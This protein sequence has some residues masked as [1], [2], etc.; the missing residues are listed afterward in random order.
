MMKPLFFCYLLFCP[1]LLE[2]QH[3]IRHPETDVSDQWQD[4]F[5]SQKTWELYGNA[6]INKRKIVFEKWE[7][8]H[9]EWTIE[10]ERLQINSTI[11]PKIYDWGISIHEDNLIVISHPDANL[12]QEIPGLNEQVNFYQITYADQEWMIL[13]P[14]EF[15]PCYDIEARQFLTEADCAAH[16]KAYQK[17]RIPFKD[18]L[19]SLFYRQ[20][21]PPHAIVL[22]ALRAQ[23]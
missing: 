4:I 12:Y 7:A 16:P 15:H 20:S 23:L 2:A 6:K 8:L 5:R 1:F 14:E 9:P 10:G 19:R 17:E 18:R 13:S 11:S 3:T 21:I 22:R